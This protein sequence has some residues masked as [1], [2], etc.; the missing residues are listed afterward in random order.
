[1]PTAMGLNLPDGKAT[2]LGFGVLESG[3]TGSWLNRRGVGAILNICAR[4]QCIEYRRR[5]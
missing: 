2:R 4:H 3:F 5:A 1:M